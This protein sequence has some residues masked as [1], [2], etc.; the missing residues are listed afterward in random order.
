[1]ELF[2]VAFWALLGVFTYLAFEWSLRL[3]ELL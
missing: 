3:L 2:K 1:M